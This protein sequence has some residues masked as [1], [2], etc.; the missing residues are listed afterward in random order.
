MRVGRMDML[1]CFGVGD[2]NGVIYGGIGDGRLCGCVVRVRDGKGRL[3]ALSG[4]WP[5]ILQHM[6]ECEQPDHLSCQRLLV[7]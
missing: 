4:R 6:P 3:V 1:V 7:L 2:G 5:I